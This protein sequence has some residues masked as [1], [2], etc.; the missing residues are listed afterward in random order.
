MPLH[1]GH[2][3]LIRFAASNCDELIVSMTY[4]LND[5][6]DGKLRFS[7]I[8]EY[9]K[10]DPQIKPAISV[11]DFDQESL[12]INERTKLWSTF[13]KNRFPSAD[14]LFTSE[15]Y[16]EP[17]ANHLGIKHSSFD[18]ERKLT[19]ISAS[20]IRE[21]PFDYWHSSLKSYALFC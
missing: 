8:E 11:D 3:A 9:F 20:K 21:R 18:K 6:I 17:F 16:G 19:P 2:I 14:I 15:D 13:I 7:W 5:P 1:L 10:N 4:K 12:P